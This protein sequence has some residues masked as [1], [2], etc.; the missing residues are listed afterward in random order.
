MCDPL[1]IVPISIKGVVVVACVCVR[2]SVCVKGFK[3]L[4]FHP[5]KIEGNTFFHSQKRFFFSFLIQN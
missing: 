5:W 4:I 1:C 3:A 2:V